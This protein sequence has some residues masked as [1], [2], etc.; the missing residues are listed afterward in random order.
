M[1][2]VDKRY[3]IFNRNQ[4]EKIYSILGFWRQL[5]PNYFW[6]CSN[7]PA[8]IFILRNFF[9]IMK[10][11]I[12]LLIT[13]NSFL[14]NPELKWSWLTKDITLSIKISGRKFTRSW[15]FDVNYCAII[16]GGVQMIRPWFLIWETFSLWKKY[17]KIGS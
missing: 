16:L 12:N 2:K 3:C 5:L 15:H 9:F 6:R 17:S 14:K 10:I 11:F 8:L 4:R 7:D 1:I 13:R